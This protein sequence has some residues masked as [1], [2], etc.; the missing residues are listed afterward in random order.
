ML[1]ILVGHGVE[2]RIDLTDPAVAVE[3][4]AATDL[5]CSA[6]QTD[7]DASQSG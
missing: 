7:A 2:S 5:E 3:I 1:E 6:E 4:A